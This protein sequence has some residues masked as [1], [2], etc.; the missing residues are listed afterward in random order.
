MAL[1]SR[2]N[3][4]SRNPLDVRGAV[5]TRLRQKNPFYVLPDAFIEHLRSR[6]DPRQR[7]AS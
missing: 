7:P 1:E 5:G 6:P 2:R 4:R 3:Q